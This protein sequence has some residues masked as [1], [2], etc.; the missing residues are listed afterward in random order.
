[1]S[2]RVLIDLACLDALPK[3]GKRRNEVLSFCS[4]LAENLYDASD[5]Q[6]TE[7]STQRT[8][9]VSEISGFAVTWWVDAPVKRVIIID[10]HPYQ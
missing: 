8:L 5:F 2:Y 1:M 7:P 6:I 9:E 3:S 10:I 4:K